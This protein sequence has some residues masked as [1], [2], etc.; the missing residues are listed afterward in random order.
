[1][2]RAAHVWLSP[3]RVLSPGEIVLDSVGRV[4]AVRPARRG[5]VAPWLLA[6]GLVDAHVHLQLP[7]L[8]GAPRA[9]VPWL[10][11]VI[12]SRRVEDPHAV[13]AKSTAAALL[14]LQRSGCTAVGEIDSLGTSPALLGA[15]GMA[16]RV[17]QEVLGFDL[18]AEDA[19]ELVR[20]RRRRASKDLSSGLSPHAPYSCSM[21]LVRAARRSASHIAVHVAEA[22]EEVRLLR[23]GTGPLR[24]LLQRLGRWRPR[25][26][27]P[28]CSPVAW[29]DACGALD[30]RTLLI[31]L[32]EAGADDIELVA[33][34][35]APVVVCPPTIDYFGRQPPD[36]PA[37]R[38]A[39]IVV[40]LGTDSRASSRGPLSMVRAMASARRMW[41]SLPPACVLDL[42]TRAGGL[43]IGRPSLGR[44]VV[45]GRADLCAFDLNSLDRAGAAS[46]S[47]A[48][49]VDA[50]TRGRLPVVGTWLRGQRVFVCEQS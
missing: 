1:M 6:P 41:P 23:A 49:V 21:A 48:E 47:S 33:R 31:H 26:R 16:G 36:V 24:A 44:I 8:P 43:A 25:A 15:A 19:A 42:A 9:F 32:Q 12:D 38:R 29:L 45:G 30:R 11:R 50:A 46:H 10:Q 37:W 5:P 20:A 40:A 7:A 18:D 4:A 39:G 2:L 22:E 35:R 13:A 28:G 3:A 14:E 34:R 27:P 17:Y